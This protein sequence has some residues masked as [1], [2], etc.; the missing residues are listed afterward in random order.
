[1]ASSIKNLN[2]TGLMEFVDCNITLFASTVK[3]NGIHSDPI[4]VI[5]DQDSK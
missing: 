2:L 1:M 4:F 5:T 3:G